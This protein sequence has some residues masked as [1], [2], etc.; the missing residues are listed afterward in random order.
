MD[1]QDGKGSV[2]SGKVLDSISS[3][4]IEY[5]T[6]SLFV[7]GNKKPVN[8]ATSNDQGAFTISGI[9]PGSY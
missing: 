1:G 7:S 2:I 3:T 4:P 5:A 6:V 9:K 8:G